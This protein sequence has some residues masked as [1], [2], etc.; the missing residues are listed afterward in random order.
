MK[1]I[2]ILVNI[3]AVLVGGGF[4]LMFRG[5]LKISLQKL[6]YRTMGLAVMAVAAYEFI[7]HYFVMSSGEVELTGSLLVIMA[8][9]VGGLIGYLFN[10]S[11]GITAIGKTLSKKDEDEKAKESA[12][13]DR[14]SRAVELS[15]EKDMKPPKVSFLD[16]LPTYAAPAPMTNNAYADG[17]LIGIVLFCA[18][19]MLFNGV[20]ADSSSGETTLLLVKSV[21]DFVACFLLCSSFGSGAMYATI[22]MAVLEVLIFGVNLVLPNFTA[23]FF[24]PTLTGQISVI[25]A[26]ILLVLGIQMAFDRKKPK[27]ADLLPAYLIPLL[28][29]GILFVVN[30]FLS[31]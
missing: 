10:I 6:L 27:A 5:K 4:G 30:L 1:G 16:K 21:I 22:P 11:G 31:D 28:Y 13:L 19:S 7:Q 24:D 2:G 26:V 23:E 17:F 8:L 18:N 9:V 25:G 3:L 14:L 20:M 29:Y 15:V 12:R